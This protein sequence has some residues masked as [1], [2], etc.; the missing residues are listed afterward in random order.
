[1]VPD[2]RAAVAANR[3][4]FRRQAAA[5]DRREV[6]LGRRAQA[7][8]RRDLHAL[9]VSLPA[10]EPFSA[11]DCGAGTG[12]LGIH[13]LRAG[14]SVTALD[15]S[16]EMLRVFED[17]ARAA[18]LQGTLTVRCGDALSLLPAMQASF[19]IVV[20]SA[21]L[22]HIPDYLA[23]VDAMAARV[24]PGGWLYLAWEPL[25]VTDRVLAHHLLARLDG[26]LDLL[27][28][29]PLGVLALARD[30]AWGRVWPMS[31]RA[32]LVDVHAALDHAAIADRLRR[33]G[34]RA[35][36][37]VFAGRRTLVGQVGA[38]LLHLADHFAIVAR[39]A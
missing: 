14:C 39:R 5:Y 16:P 27:G 6:C 7:R 29:D 1:M 3:E 24:R 13:L 31:Q 30:A 37:R 38:D 34:F 28:H 10:G 19:A 35:T 21:F 22:H 12:A 25:A 15:L 33:G 26:M 32:P 23:A 17:K 18:G 20:C 9:C 36:A 11:L 2:H 8:I 4:A